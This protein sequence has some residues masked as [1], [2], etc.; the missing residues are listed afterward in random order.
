MSLRKLPSTDDIREGLHL[1]SIRQIFV[2][3]ECDSDWLVML[4]RE[5]DSLVTPFASY[6]GERRK[7]KWVP[8]HFIT[9]ERNTTLQFTNKVFSRHERVTRRSEINEAS[10]IS[11]S[12]RE[13]L[14]DK[15]TASSEEWEALKSIVS[16]TIHN[17][18]NLRNKR[19]HFNPYH[20]SPKGLL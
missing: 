15:A 3:Q 14:K 8:C 17:I 5:K 9:E 16:K 11:I 20:K 2:S 18:I 7:N 13:A 6:L 12:W 10:Q 19:F 1:F 4:I